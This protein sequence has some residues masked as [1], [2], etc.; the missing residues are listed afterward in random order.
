MFKLR[1]HYKRH[2]DEWKEE[3]WINLMLKTGFFLTTSNWICTCYQFLRYQYD[4]DLENDDD[5]RSDIMNDT[6]DTNNIYTENIFN[7]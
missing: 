6:T 2:F 7:F 3:T 4:V 1:Y 5:L